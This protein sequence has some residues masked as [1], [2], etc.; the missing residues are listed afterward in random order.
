MK[1]VDAMLAC[2][3][4]D[5]LRFRACGRNAK[6]DQYQ[7]ALVLDVFAMQVNFCDRRHFLPISNQPTAKG[8]PTQGTLCYLNHLPIPHNPT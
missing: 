6:T 4:D 3:L 5:A 2:R 7:C 8:E 1:L